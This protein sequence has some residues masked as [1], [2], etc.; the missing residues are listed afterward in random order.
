[1]S[2]DRD[3]D[4]WLAERGLTLTETRARA[5]EVLE[6]AGLTRQG[7][8]R[9]SEPKLLRAAELLTERF[10]PVCADP[11]C[12][13][14]A[15]ASGRE[16]LRVEPRSHCARC[17]G[18]A[19]HRA[20]VAFLEACRRHGVHRVVVVGG[21]PAVREELEAKLGEHIALRMVDGTER[22][23]ADRA[24]SDL[25]WG[26]LVLVWGATELHHKVSGHYTHGPSIHHHKVVHVVRRGVAALLDEAIIHLQRGP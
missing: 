3:I 2:A 7:K 20:E 18:S 5:R 14:V 19:N 22:R 15:R 17:G 23:T 1:M 4:G 12:L 26:D 10:F 11:A 9:M 25:E 8:A 13:Q 16:P 21:S 24:K 6:G